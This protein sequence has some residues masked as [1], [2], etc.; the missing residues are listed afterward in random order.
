MR[1]APRIA[2]FNFAPLVSRPDRHVPQDGK[3]PSRF[4]PRL[5]RLL[6]CDGEG[7]VAH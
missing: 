6:V 4:G 3:P 1:A 5:R 2:R 7:V